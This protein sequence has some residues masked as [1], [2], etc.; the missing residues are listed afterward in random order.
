MGGI[1]RTMKIHWQNVPLLLMAAGVGVLPFVNCKPEVLPALPLAIILSVKGTNERIQPIIV[2]VLGLLATLLVFMGQRDFHSSHP[3]GRL[4][5]FFL[6]LMF[7]FPFP[8][9]LFKTHN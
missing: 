4:I 7:T 5:P 6:L 2:I 8:T 9:H 1:A 3:Q